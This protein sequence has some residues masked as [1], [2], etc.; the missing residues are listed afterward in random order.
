[1]KIVD[2]FLFSNEQ[3]LLELRLKE[4]YDVV[5]HFVL[6]EGSQTFTGNNKPLVYSEN[7]DKYEKYNDKIIHI[8]VDVLI[9]T[10]NPWDREYYQRD[11]IKQ[12]IDKLTLCDED[13]VVVSDLDEIPDTNTLIILK[14][15][16]LNGM[17]K[18]E[19]EMY[20]YNLN[21]RA[22]IPWDRAFI[23]NKGSLNTSITNIRNYS[24]NLP[25][26]PYKGGWHF[27]YFGD[28]DFI[29][30]KI[31]QNS[32]SE[33]NTAMYKNKEQIQERIKN[34]TDLYGRDNG[35]QFNG[36]HGFYFLSINDNK[37]LPKNFI[38]LVDE[39]TK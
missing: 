5:D 24:W 39:A 30:K 10:N 27:S 37:Y 34:C 33:Y 16:G 22:S 3:M 29:I 26:L 23:F 15:I 36:P 32:H 31:E 35:V 13:I 4:L 12:G 9:E 38:M 21:C 1:M 2:C 25:K 8:V 11:C 17:Y 19:Q 18:L 6:V 20:Y 7:R 28:V 14:T